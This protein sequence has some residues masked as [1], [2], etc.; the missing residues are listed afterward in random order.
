[1]SE[2]Q[3][4]PKIIVA[5][6]PVKSPSELKEAYERDRRSR[7]RTKGLTV[8]ALGLLGLAVFLVCTVLLVSNNRIPG[9]GLI[10]LGVGSLVAIFSGLI[11]AATAGKQVSA[12]K[13]KRKN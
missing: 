2:S 9:I 5:S 8:F 10:A 3:P 12:A 11:Q 4:M 7:Q 6:A 13:A 1:M